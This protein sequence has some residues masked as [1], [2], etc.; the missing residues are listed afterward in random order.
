MIQYDTVNIMPELR[1]DIQI[2]PGSSSFGAQ[3]TIC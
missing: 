2:E 3:R 1:L